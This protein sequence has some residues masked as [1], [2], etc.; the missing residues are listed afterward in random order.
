MM[1]CLHASILKKCIDGY[2]TAITY[3][4]NLSIRQGTF[5]NKLKLAKVIPIFKSTNEQLINNY[6]PISV[7]PFISKI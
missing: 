1:R 3:L 5:P 6:R 7:L 4:V 2:I